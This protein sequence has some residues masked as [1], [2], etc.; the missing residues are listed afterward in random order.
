M[1]KST[2]ILILKYNLDYE[3]AKELNELL[4]NVESLNFSYS[5]QLSEYIVK[6]KLGYQYPNISGI[7]RMR[8]SGTE[9]DFPGGFPP[10]IYAIICEEL[11]L[12][13]QQTRAEP[14]AFRPFKEEIE[15]TEEV[16]CTEDYQF[17]IED[18]AELYGW[19]SDSDI[20]AEDWLDLQ[21]PDK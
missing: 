18:I 13:N 16:R 4:R 2:N 1:K 14:I 17:S 10:R 8:E 11:G 19:E 12:K 21:Y 9:W 15:P 6:N 3:M 7:V 20:N 5:K